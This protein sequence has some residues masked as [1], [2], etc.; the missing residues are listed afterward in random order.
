M[1]IA[2]SGQVSIQN[3]YDCSMRNGPGLASRGRSVQVRRR[4]Q[5]PEGKERVYRDATRV[6]RRRAGL[7]D[8][9]E[10]GRAEATQSQAEL[11]CKSDAASEMLVN[12]LSVAA[13][14][15]NP[16]LLSQDH[17]GHSVRGASSQALVRQMIPHRARRA[18][19]LGW[20]TWERRRV[21]DKGRGG[22]LRCG[23]SPN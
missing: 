9:L 16:S 23:V 20:E 14:D 17:D 13:R 12:L 3:Q 1:C 15:G 7:V 5:M 22:M 2:S 18:Q 4:S 8:R 21:P 10:D 19:L 11:L 6:R